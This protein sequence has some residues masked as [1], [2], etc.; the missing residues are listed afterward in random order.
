M[1]PTKRR[2]RPSLLE[3]IVVVTDDPKLTVMATSKTTRIVTGKHGRG[4]PRQVRL[5]GPC[6]LG[7]KLNV[8]DWWFRVVK[9]RVECTCSS[10]QMR[11][12]PWTA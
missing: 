9:P 10:C 7:S 3:Q 4:F 2:P 8:G 12:Y 1:P 6:F 5:C 11:I